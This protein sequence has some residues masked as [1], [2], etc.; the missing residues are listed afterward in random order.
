MSAVKNLITREPVLISGLVDAI[1]AMCVAF[2][3]DLTVEQTGSIMAVVA[4]V[5]AIIARM[6]VTPTAEPVG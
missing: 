2:G 6:F 5:T 1:I 3:L 4:V